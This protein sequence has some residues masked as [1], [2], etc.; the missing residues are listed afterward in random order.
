MGP[1]D[2]HP[3]GAGADPKTKRRLQQDRLS[4]DSRRHRAVG[5]HREVRRRPLAPRSLRTARGWGGRDRD[6]EQPIVDPGAGPGPDCE[7]EPIAVVGDQDGGAGLVCAPAGPGPGEVKAR[8]IRPDDVRHR[9]QQRAQLC[10]PVARALYRRRVEAERDVVDENLVVHLGQVDPS[11]AAVDERIEG[12]DDVIAIDAEVEREV[13][14][15]SR[16]H[17]GVG[18]VELRGDRGHDRL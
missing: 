10:L 14:S 6:A 9:V 5:F 8:P 15:G 4:V 16:R 3:Q 11:L 7:A 12:A 2:P 13:V 18:Q 1:G 17:A